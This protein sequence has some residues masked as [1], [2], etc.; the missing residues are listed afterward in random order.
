VLIE[1]YRIDGEVVGLN[2]ASHKAR[3]RTMNLDNFSLDF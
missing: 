1:E 3:V 2:L